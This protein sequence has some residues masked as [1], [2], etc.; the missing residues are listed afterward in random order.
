[1]VF[2]LL[3]DGTSE[4]KKQ[5]GSRE[6]NTVQKELKER[7]AQPIA[8]GKDRLARR[9][10]LPHS[11]ERGG[12]CCCCCGCRSPNCLRSVSLLIFPVAVW[13]I[14]AGQ[15]NAQAGER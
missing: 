7:A 2:Y 4:K 14:S 10:S 1:M 12:F 13:G 6:H 15:G 3:C 9:G 11:R 8:K 5:R